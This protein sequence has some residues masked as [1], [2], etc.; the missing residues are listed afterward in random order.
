MTSDGILLDG[1]MCSRDCTSEAM[2]PSDDLSSHGACYG[3]GGDADPNRRAC[4]A[5]CGDD[6]DCAPGLLCYPAVG[7]GISDQI[8]I[9]SGS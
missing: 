5:R 2:C 6:R 9:P 3:I 4:Y 1:R 8:C 7:A